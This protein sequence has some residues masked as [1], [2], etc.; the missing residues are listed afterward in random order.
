MTL[1]DERE[2][3]E[4]LERAVDVIKPVAPPLDALR[5][6]ARRRSRNRRTGLGLMAV[7]AVAAIVLIAVVVLPGGGNKQTVKPA[8]APSRA[9]LVT[10]ANA[11]HALKRIVGPYESANGYYGA[12]TTKTGVDV[13]TYRDG[14]WQLSGSPVT[15]LGNGR[16]IMRMQFTP[17]LAGPGTAGTTPTIYIRE[18]GGDITY[19]GWFLRKEG[20]KW[21][22][23]RFGTCGHQHLCYPHSNSEAYLHQ[24]ATGLVS[25]SNNCTP[26]CAAGTEYRIHWRWSAG[27]QEFVATDVK[28]LAN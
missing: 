14:A 10:F 22:P 5:A 3:R 6:R 11:N 1:I 4:Q 25:V 16:W 27:R 18:M 8:H 17:P 15:A 7:A 24:S 2:I 9:S 28:P 26:D 13:T 19:A 21:V 20:A 23:A 12:F